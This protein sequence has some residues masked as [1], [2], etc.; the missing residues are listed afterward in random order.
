VRRT[1]HDAFEHGLAADQ[2]FFATFKR[3]QKLDGD[4]ES[5]EISQ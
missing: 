4:Q 1:H 2:G 3:G 5:D